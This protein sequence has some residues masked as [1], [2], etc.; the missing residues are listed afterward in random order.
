MLYNRVHNNIYLNIDK[1]RII[2]FDFEKYYCKLIDYLGDLQK[3]NVIKYIC[4]SD[5]SRN[6]CKRLQN[7]K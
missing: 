4:L 5:F 6:T 2:V 7:L 3:Q 1:I